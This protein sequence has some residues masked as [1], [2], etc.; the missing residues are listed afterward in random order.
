MGDWVVLAIQLFNR[1][2]YDGIFRWKGIWC[3]STR[4]AQ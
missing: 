2:L 1:K 3:E 4:G